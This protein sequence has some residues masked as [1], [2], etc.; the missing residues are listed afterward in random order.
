MAKHGA[1]GFDQT[2]AQLQ[3]DISGKSVADDHI[4]IAL[5][6]VAS[7]HISDEVDRS[8]FQ[9]LER[10]FRKLIAL[11]ILFADRQQTHS[12]APDTEDDARINVPHDCEL[13]E[14]MGDKVAARALA[15]CR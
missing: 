14:M 12:R 6:D 9:R 3:R 4:D 1:K 15:R 2:L 7:L 11:G 5:E 10:F 13:L 8:P